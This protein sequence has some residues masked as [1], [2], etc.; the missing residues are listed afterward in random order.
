MTP[1]FK[2]GNKDC[3]KAENCRPI[4]FIPIKCKVL[5]HIIHR[6]NI[7]LIG[8]HSIQGWTTTGRHGVTRKIRTKRLNHT[9]NMF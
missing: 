1:I 8:I 3:S 9:G 5:E 7:Y 4:S 6:N 2:D